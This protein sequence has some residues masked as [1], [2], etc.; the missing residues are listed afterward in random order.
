MPREDWMRGDRPGD[1]RGPGR[2]QD[3]QGPAGPRFGRDDRIGEARDAHRSF[4]RDDYGQADY[5]SDFNY[6]PRRRTGYRAQEDANVQGEDFGQADYSN[7]YAYDRRSGRAYR[8]FSEDDRDYGRRMDQGDYHAAPG[9]PGPDGDRGDDHRD[10]G[11]SWRD[12][13][14]AFFGVRG[15]R[16]DRQ[17]DPRQSRRRG[18]SD[19]VLWAVI[20]ERL[21]DERGLDLRDLEVLVDNAEV[22]LN[23]TVRRKADKRRIEDIAD[24]EG[25]RHVQNNLRVRDRGWF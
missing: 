18:P 1:W 12:R 3:D 23:G 14:G 24:I 6:D 22:T 2:T 19:R 7:D 4:G 20:V 8:R 10:G 25:V 21:E 9:G 16:D 13:A 15:D 11:R 17:E 5:S